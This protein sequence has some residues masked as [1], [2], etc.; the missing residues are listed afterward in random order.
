M[1]R[2][3]LSQVIASVLICLGL[4]IALP[5][6]A[7]QPHYRFALLLSTIN[8]PYFVAMKEAAEKE[9]KALGVDLQVLDAA[10]SSTT[11]V[12][13]IQ[14]MLAKN[15]DLLLVNPTNADTIVPAIKQA[16]QANVPVIFLDRNANGGHALAFFASDNVEAGRIACGF[17]ARK[18]G[19]KGRVAELTGVPGASA[20][21]ERTK[22]CKEVLDANPGLK[23]VAQ[24]TANFDR[25]QGL[26]VMQNIITANPQGIDALFAENDEMALG[27]V[28]AL[29]AAKI[30]DKTLVVS[31]DGTPD[32]LAAVKK[33][34]ISLDVGQQ[35]ALMSK[36]GI[37][38]GY[39]YL[40][41][42]TLFVPV[43]LKQYTAK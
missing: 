8:N 3:R 33:G 22:G 17:I 14:S 11:Q 15:V 26:D 28:K 4:T 32:G 30:L 43:P 24:Q 5:A 18:L 36:L 19:G 35:P 27:A 10:N 29:K 41:S 34:E 31:I 12:N 1:K 13:Q 16:N 20:T 42:K 7:A 21:V 25:S 23:L 37:A 39:N 40:K 9:A 2:K 38:A 6:G